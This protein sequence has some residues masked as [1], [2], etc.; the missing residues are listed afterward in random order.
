[1]VYNLITPKDACLYRNSIYYNN[2]LNLWDCVRTIKRH[3]LNNTWSFYKLH[4]TFILSLKTPC[5]ICMHKQDLKFLMHNVYRLFLN[6]TIQHIR[7][8]FNNRLS[9]SFTEFEHDIDDIFDDVN[10]HIPQFTTRSDTPS[11]HEKSWISTAAF[12]FFSGLVSAYRFYKDYVFKKNMK[13]TLH[14]ILDNQNHFSQNIL[15][16]K[17]NLLSFAEITSGNFKDVREDIS[18]SKSDTDNKFDTYLTQLM[19][20][21]A[22]SIFYKNYVLCYVNI[23]YHLN[24][25]LLHTTIGLRE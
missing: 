20:S 24:H 6:I 22:N 17:C 13:Q 25:D 3:I 5:I 2:T 10:A 18:D 15:T 16:N 11:T 19:H 8:W 12:T 14:Y 4:L 7:I 21:S 9:L 1:M 23:L